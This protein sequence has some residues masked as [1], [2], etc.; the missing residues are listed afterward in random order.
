MTDSSG[1]PNGCAISNESASSRAERLKSTDWEPWT[2]STWQP[3]TSV[4]LRS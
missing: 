2:L 3:R 4:A 1:M